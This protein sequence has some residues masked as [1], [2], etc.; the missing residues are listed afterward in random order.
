MLATQAAEPVS[1][2]ARELEVVRLRNAVGL[3]DGHGCGLHSRVDC[4]KKPRLQYRFPR[5][6]YG[7]RAPRVL[8]SL[9][10]SAAVFMMRLTVASEMNSRT[11]RVRTSTSVTS[12]ARWCRARGAAGPRTAAPRTS[13]LWRPSCGPAARRRRR[14]W[15]RLHHD[16]RHIYEVFSMELLEVTFERPCYADYAN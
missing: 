12:P 8:G 4:S 7:E 5:R 11:K 2:E 15:R 10:S 9:R 16:R 13:S 6:R 1:S 3:S 14:P